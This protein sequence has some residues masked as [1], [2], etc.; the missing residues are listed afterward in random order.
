MCGRYALHADPDVVALQFGLAA[1][2]ALKARYNICPGS[3]VLAISTDR[4]GARMAREHRWG[5]IPHWAKDPAI[6][7]K[8]ANARGED[9]E[10]RAA[11]RDAFLRWRCLVPASGYFE[12]RLVAR[13]KQPWYLH[14]LDRP[15]FGLAGIAAVWHGPRGPV[16][17]L[18]LITGAPNALSA[19]IHERMPLIIA[20]EDYAAW[21]DPQAEVQ[22][23]QRLVR[24]YP[25]ERMG[26]YAVSPRVNT[27][28]NDDAGLVEALAG[29]PRQR[30]L[31]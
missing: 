15:L 24:P 20:P 18:A 27:P 2:P 31:L 17:S 6:G 25:A 14:P 11:F 10:R 9:L 22:A 16:R 3:D 7:N 21:L 13:A 12:W 23:L 19:R 29:G 1:A 26:G 30:D 8:L 28:D 4:H 5:L